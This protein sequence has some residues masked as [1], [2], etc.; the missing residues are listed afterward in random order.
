MHLTLLKRKTLRDIPSASGLEIM[1]N[2]IYIMSDDSP[3]LFRLNQKFEVL[4]KIQVG[5]VSVAAEGK[6]PKPFKSDLEAM[7]VF[8]QGFLLFGSGS[9]SPQRDVLVQLNTN[10]PLDIKKYSLTKFYDAICLSAGFPRKDLNIEAAVIIDD[11][12]YLFNRGKNRIIKINARDFLEYAKGF[13]EIPAFK[14]YSITL[15]SLNGLVAGFS[16]ACSTPDGKQIIFTA[17]VENTSNWI[18]D[19]EVCGSF[20]GIITIV[21]LKD[22]FRP[23]CVAMTDKENNILKIKVE[24]VAVHHSISSDSLRLLMVTDTDGAA[25]EVMEGEFNLTP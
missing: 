2:D 10:Q 13:K 6:I 20:V 25:S 7:A 17:S 24:S 4:D 21:E 18:D 15:P 5:D 3:W 19:G 12:L 14:I 22:N 16:G 23:D 9:K 8:E 1:G 11:T